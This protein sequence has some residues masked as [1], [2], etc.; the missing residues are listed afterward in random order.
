MCAEE[1]TGIRGGG[2][3][4]SSN[5]RCRFNI[6]SIVAFVPDTVLSPP[7]TD[8]FKSW[9]R[10]MLALG[11]LSQASLDKYRPMWDAW[12]H[13]LA[14]QGLLWDVV[15]AENLDQFL[16]GAAPGTGGRR[17]ALNPHR[18]STY[19]RQRYWRLLRGVYASARRAGLVDANPVL[20]LP[21]HRRPSIWRKDR[22]SQ[23]LEPRV[24]ENLSQAKTLAASMPAK[25]DHQWW[26]FRDRAILAMLVATGITTSELIALRAIDV[27]A[28]DRQGLRR[29]QQELFEKPELAVVV[30]V[31][32]TAQR[33]DRSIPFVS[34]LQEIL[35]D[36]MRRRQA[37]IETY[38]HAH[39]PAPQQRAFIRDMTGK[40]PLFLARRAPD[41]PAP[42]PAMEPVTVYNTVGKALKALRRQMGQSD[43]EQASGPHV[44]KGPA[45]VR[46][47]VLRHWIDTVGVAET[48]RLAGLK[49]QDSLRFIIPAGKRP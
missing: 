15:T 9:E 39:V 40:G 32:D 37:L 33:V 48:V 18:M 5:D 7:I 38:A 6:Y 17:P 23:I 2:G 49:D 34:D 45:V 24:F 1:W 20:D 11:E 21:E 43:A 29:A 14:A 41:S 26:H 10:D 13:W 8:P 36:W 25:Y 31:M 4:D 47:T 46:N 19:T 27:C 12:C 28:V 22:L 42:F 3:V 35:Y 30:D 44:A 16:Q